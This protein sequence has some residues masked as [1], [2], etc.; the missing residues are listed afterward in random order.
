MNNELKTYLVAAYSSR[1][2]KQFFI[3]DLVYAKNEVEAENLLVG[4]TYYRDSNQT[5]ILAK[6]LKAEVIN[7][8]N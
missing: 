8:I 5:K 7:Q 6:C 1:N 4:K 2:E 3:T